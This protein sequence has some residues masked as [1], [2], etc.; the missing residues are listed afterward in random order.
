LKPALVFVRV[1]IAS[2]LA[3]TADRAAGPNRLCFVRVVIASP[4]R[5]IGLRVE[6]SPVIRPGLHRV[7]FFSLDD[8][9]VI[10]RRR[11]IARSQLLRRARARAPARGLARDP[12]R[13]A[14]PLTVEGVDGPRAAVHLP[15]SR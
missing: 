1:C 2:L 5:R 7:S 11:S 12:P 13:L 3:F 6:T 4:S 9:E 10:T 8:R 15:E 14:A